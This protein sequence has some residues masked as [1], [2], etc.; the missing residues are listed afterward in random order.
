M[1]V[2]LAAV[3][4]LCRR[5]VGGRPGAAPRPFGMKPVVPYLQPRSLFVGAAAAAPPAGSAGLS[6]TCL[7]RSDPA[8]CLGWLPPWQH[9][10]ACAW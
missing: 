1:S 7:P 10:F 5:A 8:L 2:S 9:A 4:C 3:L 6:P